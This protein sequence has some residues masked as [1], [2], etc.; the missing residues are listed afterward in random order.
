MDASTTFAGQQMLADRRY[1]RAEMRFV[2]IIAAVVFCACLVYLRYRQA[3]DYVL[4]KRQ[5][6]D[7]EA[8]FSGR[9]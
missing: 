6:A 3:R 9:R 4:K 8:L 5:K 1:N 2:W 7:I